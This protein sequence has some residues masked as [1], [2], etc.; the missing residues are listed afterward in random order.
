MARERYRWRG[1][2]R[3]QL[4]QCVN[5]L[6]SLLNYDVKHGRSYLFTPEEFSEIESA[7]E[8]LDLKLGD[9]ITPGIPLSAAARSAPTPPTNG[10]G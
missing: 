3:G 7:A 4:R 6:T 1:V 5:R 10:R 2:V 9:T 8:M